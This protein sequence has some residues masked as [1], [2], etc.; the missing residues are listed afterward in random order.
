M[1]TA[2]MRCYRHTRSW[3]RVRDFR[4]TSLSRCWKVWGE[5]SKGGISVR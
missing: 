5:R 2:T 1:W 3:R 4:R